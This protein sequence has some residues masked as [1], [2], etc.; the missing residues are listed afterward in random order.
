[1][2]RIANAPCSWG[3]LEFDT[4]AARFDAS[5]VLSEIS[6]TGYAGTELG[7]WGFLPTDPEALASAVHGRGLTLVAAFVPAALSSA[8]GLDAAV[9]SATRTARLLAEA[10]G[11][12]AVIVLSD[13]NGRVPLRTQRAGRIRPEDGL[14]PSEWDAFAERAQHVA[15]AIREAAELRTVFH[16]HCAGYV[17]TPSEIDA[18]M[19]RTDPSLLGFCIDTGHVMYGGGDPV[20]LIRRY[21]DRLWHAHFKD[22]DPRVAREAREQQWDYFTAIRRG[23]FC[24]LGRGAVNFA[25]ARDALE[26]V[27]YNGWV[28]VEQDVLP[29]MGTPAQSAARN[30]AFLRTLGL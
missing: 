22:C 28:V 17:E 7:D 20:A 26:E 8:S 10:A 30:R 5:Q 18:L 29:G 2:I 21:G 24:E 23:L 14:S 12:D 16:P 6:A 1:V 4:P 9:H 19:S 11:F 13:D 27:G 15:R 3:I 25:A